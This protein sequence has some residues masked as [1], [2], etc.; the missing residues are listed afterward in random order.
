MLTFAL[1]VALADVDH[2]KPLQGT[3][4]GPAGAELVIDRGEISIRQDGNEEFAAIF[5][6][7]R[8]GTYQIIIGGEVVLEGPYKVTGDK[9]TLTVDGRAVE[10]KRKPVT[11][12]G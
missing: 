4:V 7:P 5:D 2:H 9:L 6:I 3:W 10:Y 12:R 1:A 11:G 8:E